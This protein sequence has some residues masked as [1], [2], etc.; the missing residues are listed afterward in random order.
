MIIPCLDYGTP[1]ILGIAGADG[2]HANHSVVCDG[3]GKG[4][5]TLFNEGVELRKVDIGTH[6]EVGMVKG[7]E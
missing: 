5:T 6:T 3:Y 7:L 1:V 4:I 2:I